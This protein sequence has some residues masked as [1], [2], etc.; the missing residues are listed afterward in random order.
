[1]PSIRT[2]TDNFPRCAVSLVQISPDSSQKSTYIE[3]NQGTN[4]TAAL[5]ADPALA[6][7]EFCM[8]KA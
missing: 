2:I 6:L 4:A 1:M 7:T 3:S 5:S 8:S